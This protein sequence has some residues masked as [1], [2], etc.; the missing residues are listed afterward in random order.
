VDGNGY[1]AYLPAIFIYH[2]L[3]FGFFDKIAEQEGY[4]NMKYDYRYEYRG[5]T[6]NKYF[7]G[8]ALAQLPFFLTAY[9]YEHYTGDKEKAFEVYRELSEETPTVNSEKYV[10]LAIEKIKFADYCCEELKNTLF[11]KNGA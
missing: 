8:T 10:N 3:H 9:F 11:T 6:V 5:H 1:Y 4:Q 7:A 2:D